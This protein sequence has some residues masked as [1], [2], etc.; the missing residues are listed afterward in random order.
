MLRHHAG[1][2]QGTPEWFKMPAMR[3]IAITT[4]NVLAKLRLID[5]ESAKPYN[6]VLSPVHIFEG[7]TLIAPFCEDR[8]RWIGLENGL[9]YISVEN[10]K[11]FRICK[12][13]EEELLI[14]TPEFVWARQSN[15]RL[16]YLFSTQLRDLD[17]VFREYFQH[18]E[19]KS[20]AP[21]GAPCASNTRGLLRRR[22]IEATLRFRL[23]GK[24]IDRH[25]QDDVNVLSDI[26][27]PEYQEGGSSSGV[28]D[29]ISIRKLQSQPIRRLM[30]ITRSGQHTIERALRGER[31]Q[32]RTLSK[33]MVFAKTLKDGFPR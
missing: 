14:W 24:E 30:R 17:Q 32:M 31:I 23:I 16:Q 6:F 27:P 26:R 7:P 15:T 22:P 25:V 11:R 12:P 3:K 1:Q 13:D 9:E 18:P 21:D 5:R 2:K 4:P 28:L 29:P 8:S 10:G 20:L 33:L 19:F